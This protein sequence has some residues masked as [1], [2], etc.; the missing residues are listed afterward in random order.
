MIDDSHFPAWVEAHRLLAAELDAQH[1]TRTGSGHTI[2][3]EQPA[4]VLQAVRDVLA[5]ATPS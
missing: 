5:A 3:V 1:V 4:L 2:Q